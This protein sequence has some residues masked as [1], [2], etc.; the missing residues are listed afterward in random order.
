[1]PMKNTRSRLTLAQR[2][3]IKQ[4]QASFI[5]KI[6]TTFPNEHQS[7]IFKAAKSQQGRYVVLAGPGSGKT[8]TAI[9]ASTT[10]TGSAIYFSY[11]KK[12]QLDTNF[13][14]VAIDSNM[15][16]VTA[17]SFGLS[18]LM[19]FNH[20]QCRVDDKETKYPT[21]IKQYLADYWDSFIVSISEEIEAEEADVNVMRLDAYSWSKTLIHYAQVSLSPLTYTALSSLV[22]EFDLTDIKPNS[23]VWPFITQAVIYAIEEGKNQFL[24]PEHLLNYDDMIYYPNVLPGV[25]VRQYDHILVDEAQDTC[26]A[27][28][29]LVMKACHKDTQVFFIGDRKQCQPAGT[30]VRLHSGEERPI[31]CLKP[32]SQVA[33]F[34]RRSAAFVKSGTVSE[35][36]IGGIGSDPDVDQDTRS[37]YVAVLLR[38]IRRDL[39]QL[40]REGIIID[41]IYSYSNTLDGIVMS[42]DLEMQQWK[43]PRAHK[44]CMFVLDIK[45]S[46]T[47]LLQGY[48]H[49]LKQYQRSHRQKK[50]A[51]H[52][53]I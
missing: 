32:S 2:E 30:M 51:D 3:L 26:R 23:L 18:C 12:I 47:F 50:P 17:H 37:N 43:K 5:E 49:G 24:G 28:L 1:M 34:D 13:K 15:T 4:Q 20:G 21:L 42:L 9:K 25:P 53:D 48:K 36:M 33:T 29:E 16:A 7:A 14:L 31:E 8:F 6:N 40:G 46:S 19:T 52:R 41:K 11:N 35:V 38:G 22:D 44:Y 10:F 39:E 45:N 27:S